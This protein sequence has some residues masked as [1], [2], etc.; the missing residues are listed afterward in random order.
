MRH[1]RLGRHQEPFY[2]FFILKKDVMRHEQI[3][4]KK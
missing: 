3:D 2:I 1:E 4:T